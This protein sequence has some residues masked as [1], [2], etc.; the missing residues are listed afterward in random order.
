M[1]TAQS[2]VSP[3][4]EV[5]LAQP[6]DF[7]IVA[8]M[9]ERFWAQ[10]GMDIPSDRESVIETCFASHDQGL[11]LVLEKEGFIVGFIGG[12][13]APCMANRDYT[14]AHE[15]AF[16]IDEVHRNAGNGQALLQGFEAAAQA[17]GCHSV[18]MI[19]LMATQFEAAEHMYQKNGFTP[20]EHSWIKRLWQ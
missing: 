13:A 12:I 1:Q 10:T 5:R 17:I 8:K 11:L 3:I 20:L 14:I 9:T 2:P 15:G 16:W 19:A 7:L 4:P 6:E 18:V